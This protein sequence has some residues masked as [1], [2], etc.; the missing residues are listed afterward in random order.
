[1]LRRFGKSKKDGVRS[2]GLCT[3]M[4]PGKLLWGPVS[5][6]RNGRER[7]PDW[8]VGELSVDA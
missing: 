6:Y 4:M 3:V 7:G 2:R 8:I 1:M 5:E